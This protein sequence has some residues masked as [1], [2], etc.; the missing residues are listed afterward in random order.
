MEVVVTRVIDGDTFD[1]WPHWD[2][3]GQR[4]SRV[5]I[6]DINAPELN[7]S[8]GYPAKLA[9]EKVIGGRHVVLAEKTVDVYHRLIARVYLNHCNVKDLLRPSAAT[10]HMASPYGDSRETLAQCLAGLTHR[11]SLSQAVDEWLESSR[12]S[13]AVDEWLESSRRSKSQISQYLDQLALR[14]RLH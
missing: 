5:R 14:A 13:Q 8:G 12:R 2:W 7:T 9:L 1:V 10:T 4:G 6:A 3:G 11:S